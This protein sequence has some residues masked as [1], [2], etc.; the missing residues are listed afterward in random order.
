MSSFPFPK[1]CHQEHTM[2]EVNFWI[3]ATVLAFG[4][5]GIIKSGF[6]DSFI[7][8]KKVYKSESEIKTRALG[9]TVLF[10]AFLFGLL[11]L[12]HE[13]TKFLGSI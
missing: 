2:A 3:V 1:Y 9:L 8:G 12:V 13:I 10:C 5:I 7:R 11:L 4:L 6:L